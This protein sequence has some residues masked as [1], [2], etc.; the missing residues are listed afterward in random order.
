MAL[1]YSR[2][3]RRMFQTFAFASH[4]SLSFPSSSLLFCF[5]S[6]T[7]WEGG[8]YT[9]TLGFPDDYPNKPPKCQFV[10]A[11]FFHPNVFPSG[12]VCLS[13][14]N[15][16][17]DWKPNITVKQILLGIQVRSIFVSV[18]LFFLSCSST[19]SFALRRIFLTNPTTV[20]QLKKKH[21]SSSRTTKLHTKRK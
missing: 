17:K 14:L 12:T 7:D 15:E 1:R 21:L 3:E 18:L 5:H 10:P 6:Q 2:K 13:I 16:E 9:L 11:G 19:S 8:L 20:I 4:S